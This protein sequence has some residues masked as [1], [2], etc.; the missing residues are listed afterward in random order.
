M[1]EKLVHKFYL[2]QFKAIGDVIS[3]YDDLHLH[4][5]HL[6]EGTTLAFETKGCSIM[7]LDE[8]EKQLFH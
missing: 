1:G 5:N 2:K 6:A 4:V 3:T 8:R 7:V